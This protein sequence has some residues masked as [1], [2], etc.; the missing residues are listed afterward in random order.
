[1]HLR[2][3][4]SNFLGQP[5]KASQE[6]GANNVTRASANLGTEDLQKI[7]ERVILLSPMKFT[8]T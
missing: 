6:M 7:H 1:M 3:Y 8:M 4:T 2:C 5:T